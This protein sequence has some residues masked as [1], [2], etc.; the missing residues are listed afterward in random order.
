VEGSCEGGN[1][2]S[3]T[4]K[5][6]VLLLAENVLVSQEGLSSVELTGLVVRW[7]VGG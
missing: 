6:G 2:L 3:G 1:E 4:I 5:Y 7:M